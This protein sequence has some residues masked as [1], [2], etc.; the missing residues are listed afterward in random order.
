MNFHSDEWIYEQIERHY[1]EALKHFPEDRIVGVFCQGSQNYGLDYEG[2]DIDTKCIILPTWEDIVFNRKPVSTTCILDNDE[3]LDVKDI[4]LMFNCFRKQN[5]N[6]LEILFTKYKK[7]SPYYA[8]NWYNLISFGRN[9]KIARYNPVAAVRTMAGMCKEK[10]HALE[11]PYPSKIETIEKYGYD[12]KQLH[13]MA[14]MTEYIERYIAGE[15]YEDCLQSK[16]DWVLNEFKL[17]PM[18]IDLARQ[19]ANLYLYRSDKLYQT[20]KEVHEEVCNPE[21]D[22]MLNTELSRILKSYFQKQWKEEE[23]K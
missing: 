10:Y 8:Y 12:P 4:R 6:F 14:R 11:H 22:E 16:Q 1:Q 9:E 15:P 13:H 2:S 18:T 21:V 3:H 23:T 20:Y 17:H 5:V 7:L 19:Y